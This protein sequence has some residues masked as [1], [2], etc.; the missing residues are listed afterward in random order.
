MV[1]SRYRRRRRR[2][3]TD[4][5]ALGVPVGPTVGLRKLLLAAAEMAI[6]GGRSAID[7]RDVLFAFASD[8][9]T[10]LLP[11]ELGVDEAAR[12]E[13]IARHR[14]A[15]EPSEADAEG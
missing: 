1:T 13:A 15:R 14:R 6:D 8:E 4:R 10:C 9:S 5:Y 3:G 7:L 2:P 12:Y 11:F